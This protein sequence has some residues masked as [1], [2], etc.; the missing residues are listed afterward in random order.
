MEKK[1]MTTEDEDLSSYVV[2]VN[3]EEQYSIWRADRPIPAGWKDAGKRGAKAECLDHIARVWTDMRPA[4]VRR[5]ADTPLPVLPPPEPAAAKPSPKN[6]LVAR[7]EVEQPITIV[8]RPESTPAELRA[9]LDRGRVF[10]LFERTGT[11]LG[12]KPGASSLEQGRAAV[13]RGEGGP[14]LLSG[15]L[16]LNYNRVRFSGTIDAKTLRGVGKLEFVEEVK[17]GA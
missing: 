12:I 7:L 10:V 9:Q 8:G 13:E 17:F 2:V 16:V 14:V 15:E 3:D 6:E 1:R 11:E 5:A 4:S